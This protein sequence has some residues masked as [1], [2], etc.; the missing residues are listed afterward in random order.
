MTVPP[1]PA[2]AAN[3]AG[4]DGRRVTT[5]D[6]PLRTDR[7]ILRDWRDSD[8]EP[9][10]ALNADPEV[11]RYFRAPLT[12]QESDA[13]AGRIRQRLAAD[14]W[15]LWAVEV[16][17]GPEFVGFVGL[18]RQT[19]EAPFTPAIEI[20]WRLARAAWGH[21]YATEAARRALEVGFG[22]LGLDEIVSMTTVTNARSRR[23]MERLGMRRDP[24]DDFDYPLL[25]EAHPLSRHVLYRLR[26]EAGRAGRH[27]GAR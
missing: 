21:G 19:F 12:R 3:R 17:D 6:L 23:V 18:A 13:F 22:A 4:L 15:G 24:A 9:F 16:V 10:A 1:E 11:M 8:L 14:G 26:S 7:L 20:G 2:I 27:V 25:P 5:Q